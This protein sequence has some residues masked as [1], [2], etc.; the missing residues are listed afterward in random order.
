MFHS[1]FLLEVERIH[2][3]RKNEMTLTKAIKV[4]EK[5]QNLN[6]PGCASNTNANDVKD[7]DK[8]NESDIDF[9]VITTSL[10]QARCACLTPAPA[11]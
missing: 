1:Y 7:N 10:K 4:P 5:E 2:L 8:I 6:D 3:E 11:E 9:D